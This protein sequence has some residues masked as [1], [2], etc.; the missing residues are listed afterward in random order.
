MYKHVQV[1]DWGERI[2]IEG[3]QYNVP[4]KPIIPFIDNF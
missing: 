1:P 4:E 3:K 2:T